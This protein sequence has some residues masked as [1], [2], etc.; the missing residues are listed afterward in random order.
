MKAAAY[1]H[2]AWIVMFL[3]LLAAGCGSRRDQ[4]IGARSLDKCSESWPVCDTMAS[5]LVADE[6]YLQGRFPNSGRFIVTLA[7]PSTVRV[8]I[9][10]E[11]VDAAGSTTTVDWYE[12]R[13]RSRIRASVDGKALVNET[14]QIGAFIRDADLLGLGDHLVEFQSDAEADYTLKVD[15]IPK[16]LQPQ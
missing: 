15:V 8:S 13:C 9:L 2:R 5:C 14:E 12:E 11:N 3:T 10:V 16:R 7:E 6:S 4:F 1:Q